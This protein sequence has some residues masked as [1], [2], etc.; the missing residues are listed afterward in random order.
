MHYL[1]EIFLLYDAKQ[2][3]LYNLPYD[4]VFLKVPCALE[5]NLHSILS[6]YE[7]YI[8]NELY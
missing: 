7:I 5:K 4:Q 1:C 6:G 2:Y 3:F 8:D